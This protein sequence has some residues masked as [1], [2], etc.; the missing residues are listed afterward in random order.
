MN[1]SAKINIR[2]IGSV[3]SRQSRKKLRKSALSN[4]PKF[5]HP[6]A[7]SPPTK[8]TET[9]LEDGVKV[10]SSFKNQPGDAV[11][12]FK[13]SPQCIPSCVA[14][15]DPRIA[16]TVQR[17]LTN[18][19]PSQWKVRRRWFK[20]IGDLLQAEI[21]PPSRVQEVKVLEMDDIGV[22]SDMTHIISINIY[23]G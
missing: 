11:Q 21:L 18:K 3:A 5:S 20:T 7:T 23:S 15:I 10:K 2:E 16:N 19:D 4:H 6:E 22:I 1:I 13:K 14:A 9:E 8:I 17:C 12:S